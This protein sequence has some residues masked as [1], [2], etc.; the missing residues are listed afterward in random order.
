LVALADVDERRAADR[1][2]RL[3]SE[4]IEVESFALD[5][6]DEAQVERTLKA[7]RERFGR[8][9]AVVNNA[10]IDM[11]VPIA[12]LTGEHWERIV[13]TNLTGPFLVT[14]HAVPLF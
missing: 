6:C 1:A 10:A 4:R 7:V 5:V 3:R 8:L 14:R 11:A 9:D 2:A 13:R 12:E